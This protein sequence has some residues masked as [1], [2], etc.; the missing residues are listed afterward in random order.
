M[1]KRAPRRRSDAPSKSREELRRESRARK[2]KMAHRRKITI[3]VILIL[4]VVIAGVALSLTVFFNI[5]SI[6]VDGSSRYSDSEI[7]AASGV[8][9]GDNLFLTKKDKAADRISQALPY[10]GNITIR[11]SLPGTLK[12]TVEDSKIEAAVVSGGRFYLINSDL[13]VLDSAPSRK[14]MIALINQHNKLESAAKAAEK[15]EAEEK[16]EASTAKAS[17]TKASA[18]TEG[19][20]TTTMSAADAEKKAAEKEAAQKAAEKAAADSVIILRGLD[21]KNPTPGQKLEVKNP[22][23]LDM[24]SKILSAMQKY[25]IDDITAMDLTLVSDIKLTYQDRITIKLGSTS[26]LDHKMALCQQVLQ[27]QNSVSSTQK[28]SLDLTIDGR[29]YFSQGETTTTRPASTTAEGAGDTMGETTGFLTAP[30]TSS[31]E[32]TALYG[33]EP[34]SV[35]S[36]STTLIQ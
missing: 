8:N 21:V 29:A 3:R 1:A 20:T 7:I 10:T 19:T 4:A 34:S 5:S 36:E 17:T 14:R 12:I 33:E 18:N 6:E 11:K 32:G 24:Y 13:K 26:G 9:N 2:A 35:S 25:K 30:V 23:T 22:G 15:N 28:G 27:E 16:A 31:A